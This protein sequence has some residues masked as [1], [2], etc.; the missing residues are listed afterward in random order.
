VPPCSR[1]D[2]VQEK[3][4]SLPLYLLVVVIIVFLYLWSFCCICLYIL[5]TGAV[6]ELEL[7]AR[8]QLNPIIVFVLF[9]F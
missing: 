4:C 2:G 8:I 6:C 9:L 3:F 5:F 1:V 7:S